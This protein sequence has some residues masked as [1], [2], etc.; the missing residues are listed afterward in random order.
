MVTTYLSKTTLHIKFTCHK[1]KKKSALDVLIIYV[2]LVMIPWTFPSFNYKRNR[3]YK[4]HCLLM[5]KMCYCDP[6][7]ENK[8]FLINISAK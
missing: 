1:N 7:G 6:K 2:T 3:I 5:E 4:Q 8:S